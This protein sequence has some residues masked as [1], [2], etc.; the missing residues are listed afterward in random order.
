MCINSSV[1]LE[2]NTLN[3]KVIKEKKIINHNKN[4]KK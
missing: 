1:K 4:K 2:T 3:L